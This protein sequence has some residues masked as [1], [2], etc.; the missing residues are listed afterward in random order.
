MPRRA[1]SRTRAGVL[2]TDESGSKRG[3]TPAFRIT[4]SDGPEV[5]GGC[6]VRAAPERSTALVE[7]LDR[8]HPERPLCRCDKDVEVKC[9]HLD[10]RRRTGF[11]TVEVSDDLGGRSGGLAKYDVHRTLSA[12]AQNVYVLRSIRRVCL[13][14]GSSA[15]RSQ[16]EREVRISGAFNVQ[17]PD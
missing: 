5:L 4:I 15:L 9:R 13:P 6:P 10:D 7:G 17:I 11:T 8:P 2:L 3:S 16:V 14:N 12:L 1:R